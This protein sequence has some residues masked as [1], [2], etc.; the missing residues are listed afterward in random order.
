MELTDVFPSPME[1]FR[2]IDPS[3]LSSISKEQNI[4]PPWLIRHLEH[5]NILG[6]TMISM[7]PWPKN[8]LGEDAFDTLELFFGIIYTVEVESH[9]WPWWNPMEGRDSHRI[10]IKC[11]VSLGKSMMRWPC[12][13]WPGLCSNTYWSY[14]GSSWWN[15]PVDGQTHW[16]RTGDRVNN[17]G[18]YIKLPFWWGKWS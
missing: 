17:W 15:Q 1:S 10:A 2:G 14:H 18:R 3:C 4:I 7:V 5:R 16:D 8:P 12:F 13:F 6:A 11:S 9:L